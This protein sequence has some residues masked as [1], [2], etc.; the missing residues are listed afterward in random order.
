MLVCNVS[1]RP[2]GRTIAAGIAEAGA[3][4]DDFGT[5]NIVFATL[6][7]DPA[8]VGDVVDAYNGE[9]MLEAASADAIADAGTVYAVAIDEAVTAI[10]VQDVRMPMVF[11]D[12]I[13]EAATADSIQ[14]FVLT[15]RA[16]VLSA[17]RAG[18]GSVVADDGG[19]KTQII[20]DIGVVK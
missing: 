13:N 4:V 14:D 7:D 8:S 17:S 11:T 19:G 9:I 3:A 12:A 6:V 10:E 20:T 1:L 16:R 18:I 15:I 2:P 5:G